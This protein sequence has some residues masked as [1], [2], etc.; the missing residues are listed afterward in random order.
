MTAHTAFLAIHI[1]AGS[2]GLILGPVAMFAPKR[3]GRHTR[4]GGVY[5][6]TMLTVCLS[7]V[8]L[9]IVDWSRVWWF[10]PIAAFSYANALSGYVAVRRKRPGWLPRHIGG[11][12]GSY[13]ALVTALLVVNAGVA[14][15]WAWSLPTIVGTVLIRRTIAARA[16]A[17]LRARP[18]RV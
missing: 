8:A 10:V 18:A 15:W 9:A 2:L 12:G 17:T 6:W 3:R 4:A 11:M 14:A 5:H 16:P 1:A 13:I 7:A